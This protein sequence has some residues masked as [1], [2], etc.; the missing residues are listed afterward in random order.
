MRLMRLKKRWLGIITLLSIIALITG[1]GGSKA[2][3]TI[4]MSHEYS[5]PEEQVS[6][7][8]QEINDKLNGEYTVQIFSSPIYNA[9][10]ILLEYAAAE[11]GL[12]VL[13][14]QDVKQYAQNGGNLAL[15]EYINPA[16]YEEGVFEGMSMKKID[17]N[18][19][20]ENNGTFLFGLP[21]EKLSLM[22]KHGLVDTQ[23]FVTVPG[24]TPNVDLS[25]KVLNLLMES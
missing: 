16:D 3:L 6:A 7:L 12:L 9:Q 20:E 17:N 18:K 2:D 22:Q 13:P 21:T 24:T 11:N 5:I 8:E 19:F 25:I 1:C 10:K 14:L 15:D 4:F 23:W